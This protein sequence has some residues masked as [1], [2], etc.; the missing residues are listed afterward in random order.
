MRPDDLEGQILELS[1]RAIRAEGKQITHEILHQLQILLREHTKRL[2]RGTAEHM[3][4]A[5]SQIHRRWN[6]VP[7]TDG[8]QTQARQPYVSREV[9]SSDA[10]ITWLRVSGSG[11]RVKSSSRAGLTK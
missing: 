6:D 10:F 11:I 3:L 7:E 4:C 9:N 5:L 8:T 2:R 1:Q